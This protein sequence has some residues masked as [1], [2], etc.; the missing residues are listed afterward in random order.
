MKWIWNTTVEV[1]LWMQ[2]MISFKMKLLTKF[3]VF[4]SWDVIGWETDWDARDLLTV[5][6]WTFCTAHTPTRGRERSTKDEHDQLFIDETRSL[7]LY[8]RDNVIAQCKIVYEAPS[9]KL[10]KQQEN[11]DVSLFF[12]EKYSRVESLFSKMFFL[13]DTKLAPITVDDEGNKNKNFRNNSFLWLRL[14]I[15]CQQLRELAEWL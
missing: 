1:N 15:G 10:M 7:Q 6:Y 3:G 5:L 4:F 14:W 11:N 8:W 2:T 13:K 9:W 12:T